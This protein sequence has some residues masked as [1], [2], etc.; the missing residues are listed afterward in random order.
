MI[1]RVCGLA[2]GITVCLAACH[3]APSTEFS[4]TPIFAFGTYDFRVTV[5][6][7]D[8]K[9]S[10]FLDVDTATIAVEN[11]F[12]RPTPRLHD[13]DIAVQFN[14]GDV[15]YRIDRHDPVHRSSYSYAVHS[16]A[17]REVC[18][19]YVTTATGSQTCVRTHNEPVDVVRPAS[20]RLG[21]IP[22]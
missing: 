12:C 8:L 3:R 20:G 6:G 1:S 15:V 21:V 14:C 22:R 11:T 2:V 9:G 16:T 18:A 4:A 13:G 17:Y 7:R 10:F 19:Q 5:D